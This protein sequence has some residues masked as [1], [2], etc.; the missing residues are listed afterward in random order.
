MIDLSVSF[1][2]SVICRDA[3]K[4]REN[5][6]IADIGPLEAAATATFPGHVFLVTP[7]TE[8]NNVLVRF[9][10][11]ADTPLYPYDPLEDVSILND[12]QLQLYT[13]Q[14]ENL[15]LAAAY[16]E[17]TGRDWLALYRKRHPPRYHMWQANYF[18][19]E[20]VVTTEETH[21]HSLPP[22]LTQIK[23]GERRLYNDFRSAALNLTLKVLS[24]EP[25][26]FEISNFLSDTEVDHI[27]E[28]AA[29]M[30][31]QLSTTR[32]GTGGGVRTN[33]ATR[34]SRNT[35][36]KRETSPI[37]DALYR[38]AADLLQMDEALLRRR[39]DDD[40]EFNLASKGSIAETLQLVHYNVGEQYTPH[41]DFSVPPAQTE[42]QPAR[43]AT[44]LFYLNEGMEGGETSFPK[45]KSAESSAQLTVKPEKGKVRVG[46]EEQSSLYCQRISPHRLPCSLGGPLLFNTP[47]RQHGRTFATCCLTRKK[48]RKVAY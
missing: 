41:H 28:L 33:E 24:C 4:N 10:I 45:W 31:L 2:L 47:R 22:N 6:Y 17:K 1:I 26:V 27:L 11:T 16:K 21:F 35:W 46:M 30:N 25:R 18:G 15:E 34:S 5:V 20:H 7:K 37:I 19:Q 32:A 44:I 13:L 36:V 48:G 14:K 3:G 23:A 39:S 8:P 9:K 38:R 43:F 40:E 42:G 12:K 29:G